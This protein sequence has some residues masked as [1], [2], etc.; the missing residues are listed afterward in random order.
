MGKNKSNLSCGALA[1][2][3]AIIFFCALL[4]QNSVIKPKPD[5]YVLVFI[6][7]LL[8][9]I[10]I[11]AVNRS[12]SVKNAVSKPSNL[13]LMFF[14]YFIGLG[15]L[16]QYLRAVT[17][18]GFVFSESL[19]E[20]YVVSSLAIG[21]WLVAHQLASMIWTPSQK[22]IKGAPVWD[23]LRLK[24]LSI[25]LGIFG[26]LMMVV[27]FFY[28]VGGVPVLAG[29]TPN[30][31]SSLRDGVIGGSNWVSVVALN[32]NS[33]G[34]IF[35]GT[36]LALFGLNLTILLILILGL[37]MFIGWG[38]RIYI[39]VPIMIV[40]LLYIRKRRP[41][42]ISVMIVITI[43]FVGSMMFAWW[44]NRSAPNAVALS[45]GT[46]V[47]TLAD[48]HL[49]PEFKE[50]L[51]VLAYRDILSKYYTPRN[52]ANAIIFPMMPNT[53]W[54]NLF[55]VN[56]NI[57]FEERSAWIIA[58]I[59]RGSSWTGIRSGII[60]ESIMAFNL[61]GVLLIF[62]ILG[63]LFS[64][65]DFKSFNYDAEN[66]YMLIVYILTVLFSLLLIGQIESTFTRVWYFLYFFIFMRVIAARKTIQQESN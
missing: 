1:I 36:Y 60:S 16:S 66:P 45:Q 37:V 4:Y 34:V 30:V 17:G 61:P 21:A 51:S 35:A 55:N 29:I 41:K 50:Y 5:S 32:A 2:F 33:M 9:F 53:I 52:I 31:D 62:A 54:S 40:G 47:E 48:L 59:T 46:V 12:D 56:K 42:F 39:L 8:A 20:A 22:Q 58:D 6:P 25:G 24:R 43:L 3:I 63:I 15:S 27:F 64:Y 7:L 57:I 23:R 14:V 65:L 26:I 13:F 10:G 19:T 44:R 49:A 28:S 11:W 18:R 38:P